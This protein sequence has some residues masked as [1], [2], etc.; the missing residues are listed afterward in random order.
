MEFGNWLKAL[1]G[2]A[3]YNSATGEWI[4]WD[5]FDK[6][7]V[8]AL[9]MGDDGLIYGSAISGWQNYLFTY[10]PSYPDHPPLPVGASL[11]SG[12]TTLLPGFNGVMYGAVGHFNS[13]YGTTELIAFRTDCTSGT[14]GAWERVTW[15]ADTPRG[16][17]IV[18]DVLNQ[19]GDV[20]HHDVRNGAPLWSID[21]ISNTTISLR[22]TLSTRD[23]RVTP[24][25]KNWR[26][27]YVFECQE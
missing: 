15:E 4:E 19:E 24:V 16:T 10:D 1:K 17:D 26:V 21:P 22:A 6:G 27:D 8:V 14:V 13:Y 2:F 11:N 25:L 3:V 7:N 18:V 9:A 5:M 23:E 12:I 20:L